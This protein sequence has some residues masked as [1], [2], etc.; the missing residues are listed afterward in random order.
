MST[1]PSCA[2][3]AAFIGAQ[4]GVHNDIEIDES[5]WSGDTV[6]LSGESGDRRFTAIVQVVEVEAA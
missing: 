6:V 4:H 1:I 3:I 2:D 5:D